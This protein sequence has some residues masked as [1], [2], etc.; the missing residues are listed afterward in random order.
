MQPS[1]TRH[2]SET[3]VRRLT[4]ALAGN[5]NC[6]KST[7]FNVLTGYRQHVGN[8]P[9]A[10]VEKKVGRVHLD[11]SVDA[12]VID[13]PGAYSLA[14]R[15]GDEVVVSDALFGHVPGLPPVDLIVAVADASNLHRHLYLTSQLLEVG[16][17]VVLALNMMDLAAAAGIKID[18][19]G[20][21]RRLGVPVVGLTATRGQGLE[22]LKRQIVGALDS[23]PPTAY[24]VMPEVLRREVDE[25]G[26]LIPER[27]VRGGNGR[28]GCGH[29]P[30]RCPRGG[31]RSRL[32]LL[33]VFL[34]NN[35]YAE[36]RLNHLD[37]PGLGEE[38][39]RRR[40]RAVE[41][42]VQLDGVEGQVRY[43]WIDRVLEGIVRETPGQV[44]TRSDAVDRVLTHRLA[45]S[46][47]FAGILAV[48]FQAIYRWAAPLMDVIDGLFSAL[49]D[50]VAAVLPDGALQ[51]LLVDGVIAGAGGVL[52]FLPQ[53]LI[54]FLFIALLEDC[55]YLARGAFLM[56]RWLRVVGLSGKSFIPL[57]SSFACAIPGIMATRT[58]ENRAD[59]L[60]TILVAP[61][62][63]CS[64]RLPVY[65]LLIGAFVPA[66]TVGGGL[67]G[68]QGLVLFAMYLV[69][70]LVA[71]PV[72]ILV[73]RL[74]KPGP[75]QAF[76]IELPGYKWPSPR[77]VVLRMYE[78][79]REFL[80]RAGTIILAASVVI[81]ALG[82]FPRPASIAVEHDARRAEVRGSLSGPALEDALAAIDRAEAGA[83]LR[84]S[85]L[86][87]AGRAIEPLVAPMGWDWRIGTAVIAAFPAR[88]V[89]IAT[90]GT[91][92][93][94]GA[95]QS[96]ESESLRSALHAAAW[97]DGRKVFNL[98]VALSIMVFFALCCQC[99]STLAVMK[100]ETN[101]WRWPVFAF[102][103]MT[104]LA[105]LAAFAAYR[106][107]EWLA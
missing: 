36:S 41:A 69:G 20:L 62:M 34:D 60:T 53:I 87:R 81:W 63:S 82:Y 106:L 11:S 31:R 14:A 100:K 107:G 75:G 39:V 6:G 9:G 76:L 44:R 27:P 97:P 83:Y 58:I 19:S 101:S 50:R 96:E 73:K 95:E 26:E 3:A 85:Y 99:V 13:L 32:E 48:V 23:D 17:P 18:L 80:L 49:G 10:T 29:R 89:V 104:S 70:L 21:S 40:R 55:G 84:G 51:S 25:L 90:M 98:P 33:H 42:G 86:G 79:G 66:T 57:L 28:C 59:R 105:Y 78:A 77:N 8:Y 102:V 91:L 47:V 92:Y 71:F 24:P 94:L 1:R 35:G 45:G 54:L 5:P 15:S 68:L 38:L 43:A 67:I 61:L 12:D 74:T 88:E 56:D 16:V 52:V 2:A 4:I 46:L 65:A 37:G 7:L 93:N 22:D 72:A 30:C 103:Q 64:A